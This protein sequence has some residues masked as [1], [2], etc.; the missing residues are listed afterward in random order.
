[1]GVLTPPP[2]IAPPSLSRL[3]GTKQSV[4]SPITALRPMAVGQ[5]FLLSEGAKRV[6]EGRIVRVLN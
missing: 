1:M 4:R 6:T 3:I 5:E 2:N